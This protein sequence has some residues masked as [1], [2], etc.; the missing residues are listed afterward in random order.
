MFWIV[1][2]WCFICEVQVTEQCCALWVSCK[3][4]HRSQPCD[5]FR[6]KLSGG[7]AGQHRVAPNRGVRDASCFRRD[8]AAK[9]RNLT[10]DQIWPPIRR[11][12]EEIGNHSL[13]IQTSKQP[14]DSKQRARRPLRREHLELSLKSHESLVS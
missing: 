14:V 13:R 8:T 10:D 1:E 2:S 6:D 9:L 4:E 12:R 3:L 11:D 5:R 7:V